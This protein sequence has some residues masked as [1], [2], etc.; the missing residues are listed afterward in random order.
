MLWLRPCLPDSSTVQLTIHS[1]YGPPIVDTM[2]MADR[3]G[4]TELY[5]PPE[6][7]NVTAQYVFSVYND[8]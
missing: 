4:L 2:Q 3:Y 7:T 8:T 5:T 1:G 6:E